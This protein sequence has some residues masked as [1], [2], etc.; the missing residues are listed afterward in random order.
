MSDAQEA[1]QRR[2]VQAERDRLELEVRHRTVELT[3]LARHLET[4]RADE[5]ARLARDLHDELSALLT[6]AKL[7]VARMR[8]LLLRTAPDLLPRFAHLGDMLNSGIALKRRI[9]EDLQPSPL[10][11]LGLLPALQILCAEF[12]DRLGVPVHT[13]LHIV[14][15]TSAAELTAFR[16]VQES[17]NNIAKHAQARSVWVALVE[18]PEHM[19]ITVR[20]DGVGFDPARVS[21]GHHGLLGMRY[22]V[23]AEEG[24][25]TVLSSPGQGTQICARVPLRSVGDD[26]S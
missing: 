19:C 13:D 20:D 17:L 15:L 6:A 7:D 3:G 4:A 2:E 16:L 23:Q 8:P 26:C 14:L 12:V 21:T 25:L 1:Q 10:S 5:K 24:E 9:I 11:T 18:Q 22:R